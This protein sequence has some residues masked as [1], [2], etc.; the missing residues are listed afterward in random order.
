MIFE[1]INENG[2]SFGKVSIALVMGIYRLVILGSNVCDLI[3]IQVPSDM[4]FAPSFEHN[5]SSKFL[6]FKVKDWLRKNYSRLRL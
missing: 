4:L 6:Y 1:H 5:V 2:L 3:G